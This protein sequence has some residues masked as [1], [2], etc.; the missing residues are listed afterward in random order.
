MFPYVFCFISLGRPEKFEE[1]KYLK[2]KTKGNRGHGGRMDEGSRLGSHTAWH[3]N[4]GNS[5][6]TRVAYTGLARGRA[7]PPSYTILSLRVNF[8]QHSGYYQT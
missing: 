3:S 6:A 5:H 1:K 7:E 4:H 2:Y 8:S